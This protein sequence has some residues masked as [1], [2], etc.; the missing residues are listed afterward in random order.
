MSRRNALSTRALGQAALEP[1]ELVGADDARDGVEGEEL[2][3]ELATL[4]D[5]EAYAVAG[6]VPG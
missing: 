1:G 4:A 6:V 3:V 2:L 5:A